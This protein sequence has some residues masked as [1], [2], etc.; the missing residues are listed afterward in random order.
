MTGPFYL[1]FEHKNGP[2]KNSK[3]IYFQKIPLPIHICCW[4]IAVFA[5][6]MKYNSECQTSSCYVTVKGQALLG[7]RHCSFWAIHSSGAAN[8]SQDQRTA[9]RSGA[10]LP[11]C[12]YASLKHFS[13][14]YITSLKWSQHK[15]MT[16]FRIFREWQ[17]RLCKLL[18]VLTPPINILS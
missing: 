13:K 3:G 11:F 2:C 1:T 15:E 4:F 6:K 14:S 17:V 10:P 18:A 16:I 8:V 12:S 5:F 7:S 9:Y